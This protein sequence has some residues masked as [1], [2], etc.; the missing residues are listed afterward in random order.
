MRLVPNLIAARTLG[1]EIDAGRFALLL[2]W[3]AA[4]RRHPVFIADRR[5][6]A[7]FLK[8]FRNGA[9]ER[10]RLFWSGER[11]EWLLARGFHDWLIAEIRAGRAAFPN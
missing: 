11:L 9:H 8:T 5:R 10:Q 6:T 1:F 7:A 3:L 4:M 2:E